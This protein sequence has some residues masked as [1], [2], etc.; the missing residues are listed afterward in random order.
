MKTKAEKRFRGFFSGTNKSLSQESYYVLRNKNAYL[1][2]E[3]YKLRISWE[4]AKPDF[5]IRLESFTLHSEYNKPSIKA[6]Y[7]S[8]TGHIFELEMKKNL[9][10]YAVDD[11]DEYDKWLSVLTQYASQ[12]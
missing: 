5:S 11:K 12:K 6:S 3:I 4:N 10:G 8:T 9:T 2:L 7:P 1:D